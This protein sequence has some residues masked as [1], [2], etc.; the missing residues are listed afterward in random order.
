MGEQLL[1]TVEYV[2]TLRLALAEL[3]GGLEGALL[4]VGLADAERART[5]SWAAGRQKE[6]VAALERTEACA[7]RLLSLLTRLQP[8]AED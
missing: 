4:E 7:E 8:A 6:L 5:A 2:E 3:R 1:L